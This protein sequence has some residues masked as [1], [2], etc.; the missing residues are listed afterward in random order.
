MNVEDNAVK[1]FVSKKPS[2][3]KKTLSLNNYNIELVESLLSNL[4]LN[5]VC[6][7][8][9]C[10][11]I[12]E[13]F[14]NKTA[15][16]MIL[17]NICTRNCLFC[18]VEHGIPEKLDKNEPD[19]VALAVKNLNLKYVVLTSVTRDDLPDGGAEHFAKTVSKIK[20]LTPHVK[21]ECLIPD[22]KKSFKNLDI[23][24]N[25]QVDVL[26]H[27]IET[28]KYNYKK[29]RPLASY[30]KSLEIL[31]YTK[32][33]KPNILTKSG[34]MLGLGENENEIKELLVDLRN[35]NCDIVTIGQYL[36]PSSS[37]YLV[38]KYYTQEEFDYFKALAENLGFKY[39]VS[40]IFVRSSYKA[41]N[42]FSDADKF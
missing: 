13:C 22:F 9:K 1:K 2:W 21:I 3:L 16:F 28:I 33:K 35:V 12:F 38:E 31:K 40:G 10:P 41:S 17:G 14:G 36:S 37:N 26:N 24:L 18:A 29:I 34:F 19:N 5:T 27:N 39:V 11:N 20:K 8:A 7:S 32:D 15:T 30:E 4:N 6:Q 25:E 42:I 23:L